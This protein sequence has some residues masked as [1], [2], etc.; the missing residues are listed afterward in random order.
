MKIFKEVT[1]KVSD[2]TLYGDNN[3]ILKEDDVFVLNKDIKIE[4]KQLQRLIDD[5]KIIYLEDNEV[6]TKVNDI[7]KDPSL[8]DIV[9]QEKNKK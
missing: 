6:N 9:K 4:K 2:C 1:Y 3:K 5:K 8:G 7:P